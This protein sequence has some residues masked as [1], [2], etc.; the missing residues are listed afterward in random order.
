HMA[1]VPGGRSVGVPGTLRAMAKA[2]ARAGKLP[3][4]RLFDPAIRLAREG[5]DVS[6]RL[7]N[8]LRNY[9]PHVDAGVRAI[10]Y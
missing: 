4:A 9:A 5:F 10:Y 8:A 1:A 2:H 7:A 3:W 6:P